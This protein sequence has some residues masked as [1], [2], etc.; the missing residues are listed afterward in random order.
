M[1]VL[2][3]SA[4]LHRRHHYPTA[5]FFIIPNWISVPTKKQFLKLFSQKIVSQ[6]KKKKK[7]QFLNHLSPQCLVTTIL[8]L[9]S[10]NSDYSNTSYKWNHAIILCLAFFISK[11]FSRFIY[12]FKVE[13][14]FIVYVYHILFIIC[15]HHLRD[16]KVVFILCYCELCYEHSCT[17]VHLNSCFQFFCVYTYKWNC[18]IIW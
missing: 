15:I 5:D 2:S 6:F 11:M 1:E 4:L 16:I 9:V 14:Y 10:M 13:E 7:K 3:A 8:H 18:W 12:I 17:N